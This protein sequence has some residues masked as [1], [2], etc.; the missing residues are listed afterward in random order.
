MNAR[1]TKTAR[2]SI[3]PM[4]VLATCSFGLLGAL[5]FTGCASTMAKTPQMMAYESERGVADES[6]ASM[7]PELAKQAAA[8]YEKAEEARE[9][10][11]EEAARHYSEQAITL[12]RTAE[13]KQR[14]WVAQTK[15]EY[16]QDMIQRL[17]Q[18]QQTA[19]TE[20]D[21][22][23][24]DVARLR[25]LQGLESELAQARSTNDAYASRLG[26]LEDQ[27]RLRKAFEAAQSL[28]GVKAEITG[29]GLTL[30]VPQ[31]FDTGKAI[32]RTDEITKVSEVAEFIEDRPDFEVIIEGHTDSTGDA[33][34]NNPLSMA[35]AR[36]VYD[37]ML[38][39][40]VDPRRMRA[41]GRGEYT[42]VAVNEA[43][44]LRG[45]NRRVEI[46]L[47]PNPAMPSQ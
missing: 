28:P 43:K 45:F 30:V 14:A 21:E 15:T 8:A 29:R 42:P 13:A 36:A 3:L 24:E 20:L 46:T 44:S 27:A 7:H 22:T 32:I 10:G 16:N 9:E 23:F 35:R 1:K 25:K 34:V 19:Q 18:R 26:Q 39:S 17:S 2:K 12:W 40:G 37:H 47:V 11:D 33:K 5:T 41:M 6:I 4:N 31:L 38:A